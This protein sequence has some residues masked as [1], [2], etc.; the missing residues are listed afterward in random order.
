MGFNRVGIDAEAGSRRPIRPGESGRH[1]W[2]IRDLSDCNRPDSPIASCRA[3]L[4]VVAQVAYRRLWSSLQDPESIL[5]RWRETFELS[6]LRMHTPEASRDIAPLVAPMIDGLGQAVPTIQPDGTAVPGDLR[7]GSPW[8]RELEQS[9]A[10]AGASMAASGVSGFDVT[11]AIQALRDVIEPLVDQGQ[12]AEI[13]RLFEWLTAICLDSW[14]MARERVQTEK[15]RELI[16]RDTPILLLAPTI[17]AINLVGTPD[18][19]AL[20][21]IFARLILLIVR[22]GA[23]A[24]IVDAT[25]LEAP[26]RTTVLE[27]VGRFFAHRK[28][29]GKVKIF[30]VGLPEE[31]EEAWRALSRRTEVEIGF[32]LQFYDALQRAHEHAGYR[33]VKT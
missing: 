3:T 33:L 24:T 10:F 9:V 15:L 26:S 12:H 2:I 31:G 21:S 20:D 17:T 14:G 25:G 7:A 5:A 18:G 11:A 4:T 13:H 32:E 19:V 6:P 8:I 23:T 30:A 27:A 29:S 22:V 28:V 16:E 1:A